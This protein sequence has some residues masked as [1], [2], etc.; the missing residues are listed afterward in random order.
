[1]AKLDALTAKPLAVKLSAEDRDKVRRQLAGLAAKE[2]LTE[3]EAKE[4]LDALLAVLEKDKATLEAA[5]YRWPGGGGE[6]GGGGPG[7]RRPP[8]NPFA[9]PP[10]AGHLK[11]L[12][13]RL[14]KPPAE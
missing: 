5:G 6:P 14:G 10:N 3:E 11:A 2:E 8:D 4:R 13:E 9:D 7:G 1:V 12:E